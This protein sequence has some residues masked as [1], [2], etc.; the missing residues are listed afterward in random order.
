MWTQWKGTGSHC[1]Y[2]ADLHG[3]ARC[4]QSTLWLTLLECFSFS[5]SPFLPPLPC[6]GHL[7][8]YLTVSRRDGSRASQAAPQTE[9][10]NCICE[11]TLPSHNPDWPATGPE[12]HPSLYT[13]ERHPANLLSLASSVFLLD[14]FHFSKTAFL[15][16]YISHSCR[17]F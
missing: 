6:S 16:G 3:T 14:H 1:K 10:A 7:A 17:L 8:S 4:F 12:A 15:W 13:I 5:K 2:M 9:H 11:K